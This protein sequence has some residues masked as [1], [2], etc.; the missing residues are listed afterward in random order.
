M[1][2]K[3]TGS[4]R[5]PCAERRL[6][7]L[8][9]W[10]LFFLL[11]GYNIVSVRA[12]E[13]PVAAGP[14]LQIA[15]I[16]RSDYPLIGINLIVTDA[17]SEPR[18]ELQG[19][20]LWE[21]GVPVADYTLEP[22]AA[23]LELFL[24]LDVAEE[25]G[26][27]GEEMGT[28][29]L[30]VQESLL[31]LAG[32]Y[33]E[34]ERDAVWLAAPD[35]EE[36]AWLVQETTDPAQLVAA[37]G[38]VAALTE[39]AHDPAELLALALDQ[40]EAGA[41]EAGRF[42]AIVLY[43]PGIG[44]SAT[45]LQAL[46]AAASALQVPVFVIVAG[47]PPT[48]AL[49]DTLS[50][51]S[52]P[53][54][55]AIVP[56]SNAAA[57]D[58]LYARLATNAVQTQV[59][60]RTNVAGDGEYPVR[61]ALGSLED[62]SVL[63]LALRPPALE[64]MLAEGSA[65][66]RVGLAPESELVDLQPA[67]QTVPVSVTW[68]DGVPRRLQEVS[69]LVDGVAHAAPFFGDSAGL[70]FEWDISTLDEGSYVLSVEA[71]DSAGLVASSPPQTIAVTVARPEPIAT[72]PPPTPLPP[73]AIATRPFPPTLIWLVSGVFLLLS[74]FLLLQVRRRGERIRLDSVALPGGQAYL[75]LETG[76]RWPVDGEMTIGGRDA[77]VLLQGEGVALFHA[78]L[79]VEEDGYWLYDEGSS[80][81]T[82]VNGEQLG[83]AG[84]RLR[85][86]DEI[87][88]GTVAARFEVER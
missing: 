31:R 87:T 67:V 16:E 9:R 30:A 34:K 46:S 48:D 23:G 78:R 53:T 2:R 42:A 24:L 3:P 44:F 66:R 37:V 15:A 83:L 28:P 77:D 22:V 5:F 75:A 21:N 6:Y 68:P 58:D 64:I 14:R 65:I 12:Q 20:R 4:T 70:A 81:G 43:T 7:R 19:L 62:S 36:A 32:R 73:T 39:A 82:F 35:G 29:L 85:D 41:D 86:G 45:R 76:R 55:G 17:A 54:R 18:L 74:L 33:I 11:F 38:E 61:V 79:V 63:D 72:A 47:E 8:A 60:Y 52:L 1:E 25:W 40:L 56:L 26:A 80:G 71:T 13:Q 88:F 84:R 49:L 51:L 10:L 69:L 57:A 27:A 59:R 50:W